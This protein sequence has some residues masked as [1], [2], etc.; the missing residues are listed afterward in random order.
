MRRLFGKAKD[1]PPPATL[2][3]AVNSVCEPCAV[4]VASVCLWALTRDAP[5]P[6]L[7]ARQ[8]DKRGGAIDDKI[9]KLDD[10]LMRHKELIARARPGPA[11]A[12]VLAVG[13]SAD[14]PLTRQ[15]TSPAHCHVSPAAGGGQA[16][17]FAGVETEETVRVC[18]SLGLRSLPVA[19]TAPTARLCCSQIRGA[20]GPTV[21]TAVQC[22]AD[23]LCVGVGAGHQGPGARAEQ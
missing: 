9:K 23:Q 4:L 6:C 18:G 21:P 17:G 12:R 22:G 1:S 15:R 11:Q 16:E 19:L 2:D 14:S 10:E 7:V 5:L 3:D 13:A 8:L 20:A